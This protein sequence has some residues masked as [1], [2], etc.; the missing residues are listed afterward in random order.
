MAKSLRSKS[1]RKAKAVRRQNIYKPIEESRIERLS[2]I[3]SSLAEAKPVISIN[4]SMSIDIDEKKLG[5]KS[6]KNFRQKGQLPNFY[7]LSKK[8]MRF[9]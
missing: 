3:Q 1:V 2:Q 5:R 6:K 8:D 4:S 9:K 7:G